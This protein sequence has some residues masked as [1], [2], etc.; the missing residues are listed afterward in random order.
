MKKIQNTSEQI[1]NSRKRISNNETTTAALR[2]ETK[3][4]RNEVQS[5]VDLIHQNEPATYAFFAKIG[6]QGLEVATAEPIPPPAKRSWFTPRELAKFYN[7]PSGLDGSGQT[8]GIV[9][10][11]GGYSVADLET[12]F[13]KLGVPNSAS[14]RR[15]GRRNYQH[16]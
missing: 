14:P 13:Q 9:E 11:G 5:F 8:I 2:D 3:K 12:Y 15:F 1:E 4:L 10:L 7:M 6:A 16:T